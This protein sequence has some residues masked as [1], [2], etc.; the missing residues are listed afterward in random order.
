[1]KNCKQK[2]LLSPI[3]GLFIIPMGSRRIQKSRNLEFLGRRK[4]TPKA[5]PCYTDSGWAFSYPAP[6]QTE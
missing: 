5:K 3:T 6:N 2:G 4:K 1:M